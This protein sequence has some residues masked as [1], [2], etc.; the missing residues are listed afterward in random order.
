MSIS[1]EEVLKIAHLARLELAPSEIEP[2]QTKLNG[3]FNLIEAMQAVDTA[4]VRPM[5]HP[6]DRALPLREDA[7]T[8][9]NVRQKA[10]LTAPLVERG[11]Y[12][13]PQVIE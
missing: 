12:L 8:E 5:S 7:V 11:L 10:Q 2:T 13:V 6:H 4:G 9:A 3:I 1:H